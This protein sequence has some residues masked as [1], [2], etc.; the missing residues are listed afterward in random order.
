MDYMGS[1]VYSTVDFRKKVGQC[2]LH[3][4]APIVNE[5]L[6]HLGFRNVRNILLTI[7]QKVSITMDC[8]MGNTLLPVGES[9]P[10][11]KINRSH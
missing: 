3:Q 11:G 5:S 6:K 2:L 8:L 4:R 1:K 10:I 9:V 7:L